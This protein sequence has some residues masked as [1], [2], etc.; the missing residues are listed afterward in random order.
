[1]TF[2]NEI[3]FKNCENDWTDLGGGLKRKI[4]GYDDNLMM[5]KVLFETGTVAAEHSHPHS[6]TTYVESGIFEV[7][8]DGNTETLR[9]GDSF[10][11]PSNKKHGVVNIEEGMLIDVFNPKRDDFLE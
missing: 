5:V 4:T 9:A 3:F 10:F 2:K 7:T 8:I 6:Q 1:M 11:V